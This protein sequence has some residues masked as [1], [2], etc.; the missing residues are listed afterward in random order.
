MWIRIIG[1][2]AGCVLKNRDKATEAQ[3]LFN[4]EFKTGQ[5]HRRGGKDAAVSGR[6]TSLRWKVEP[7]ACT[8]G[9]VTG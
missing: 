5:S 7:F 6:R 3:I 1:P 2:T 8:A 9:D 4:A